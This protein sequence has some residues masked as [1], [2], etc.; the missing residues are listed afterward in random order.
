MAME[1]FVHLVLA[2][3]THVCNYIVVIVCPGSVLTRMMSKDLPF[4]RLLQNHDV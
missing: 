3:L 4:D 2:L 1:K